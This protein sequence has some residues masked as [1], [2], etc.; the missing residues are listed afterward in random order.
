MT[1][2]AHE[3]VLLNEVMDA[4]RI[5]SGGCY[6]DGTFGRGGHARSILSRL[7]ENGR[8]IAVDKDQQAID[9][10]VENFGDD[11]RI[12]IIKSGFARINQVL[13]PILEP[14]GLDGA[15]FDLGVS[16]PQLD[17]PSRG[18]S[19]RHHGPLDM[20]MDQ[21][22]DES[23]ASWLA[24]AEQG[25][26][27]SVFRKYGEERY[28]GRIARQIIA[29]RSESPIHTTDQL[30]RLIEKIV[31]TREKGKHPATRVFQAIRIRVNQELEELQLMLPSILDWLKPGGRLAVISFHSLEDRIVKR[32]MRQAARGDDYPPDLAVTSDM[33]NPSLR[34]ISKAIR[35]SSDEIRRNPRSRSAVLRVAEKLEHK[36]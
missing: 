8:L 23:A 14:A 5:T 13:N 18:F 3:P 35:P 27:A 32:F 22:C 29:V 34:L 30:A 11:H 6:L 36:A 7:G 24:S 31:P 19:F 26:L 12:S 33:L 17:Q 16:S 4:L 10:A 1:G 15:L 20:R 2:S 21:Q 28:A 25:E 9:Y